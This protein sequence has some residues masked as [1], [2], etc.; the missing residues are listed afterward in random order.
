MEGHY[1]L[2]GVLSFFRT[3]SSVVTARNLTKHCHMFRNRPDLKISSKIWG[4]VPP[5][6]YGATKLPI[7]DWRLKRNETSYWWTETTFATA[8]DPLHS[9]KNLAN[10]CQQTAELYWLLFIYP[11][12]FAFA[13]MFTWRSLNIISNLA[14]MSKKDL[15]CRQLVVFFDHLRLVSS[16]QSAYRSKHLGRDERRYHTERAVLKVILCSW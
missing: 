5:V 7:F 1:I 13:R 6:K 8:K 4:G 14:F 12:I 16:L 3:L 2:L 10:F 11:H 15:L 9:L